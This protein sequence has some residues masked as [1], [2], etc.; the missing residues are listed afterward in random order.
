MPGR[1]ALEY[2]QSH[3]VK[4]NAIFIAVNAVDNGLFAAAADSARQNAVQFRTALGLPSRYFLFAGRLVREKGVFE[5]L[6]AYAKLEASM[7]QEIGLVFV[8]DGACR[9]QLEEQALGISPGVIIFPGFAQREAVGGLLRVGRDAYSSHIHRYVGIGCERS[10]G[11][12]LAGDSEPGSRVRRGSGDRKL[13][14][15][16]WFHHGMFHL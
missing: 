16:H 3:K 10:D 5:L 8:G 13:E 9:G 1:S 15:T 6:S 7:R 11:V 12:R 2:L 14:R 4:E